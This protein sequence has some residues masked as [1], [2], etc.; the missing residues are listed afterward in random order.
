MLALITGGAGDIGKAMAKSLLARGAT[1][2]SADIDE[3][4]LNEAVKEIDSDQLVPCHLDVCSAAEVKTAV[5][6]IFK[7]HGGMDILVNNAG[8]I[9][10]PTLKESDEEDWAHDLNLNLTA[11]WRLLRLCADYMMQDGGGAILNI[12][13]VNGLGVYGHPGYSAAKAGLINL[14]KFAA[15]E[16]GKH[17]IRTNAICPGTVKTQAWLE[18]QARN[19]EIFEQAKV[20]YPSRDVCT[21]EDVA[22]LATYIVCDAPKTMNGAVLNLDGGLTAGHDRLA[23]IFA[24]ADL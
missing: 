24:G 3:Q 2:V 18:R 20:W 7:T 9:T 10:A 14:T 4:G 21:P 13:S 6:G 15:V 17:S 23:S 5:H 16:Y 1:V 11:P 22:G 12:A 19:P 8:G